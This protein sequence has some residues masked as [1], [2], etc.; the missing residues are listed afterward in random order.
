M[1]TPRE[2]LINR[3]RATEAKLNQIRHKVVAVSCHRKMSWRTRIAGWWEEILHLPRPALALLGVA[4]MAIVALH[5][6]TSEA[7]RGAVN[8]AKESSKPT[9]E[10]LQAL[11]EQQKLFAEIVGSSVVPDADVRRYTPRPRSECSTFIA[12]V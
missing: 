9:P 1:K 3:H 6:S 12:T 8:M 5:F 4:W 10:T 11:R 2:I 7:P